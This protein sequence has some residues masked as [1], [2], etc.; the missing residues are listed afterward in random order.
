MSKD[1]SFEL[2]LNRG[3][4]F[5]G[6]TDEPSG[7]LLPAGVGERKAATSSDGHVMVR[8][9]SQIALVRVEIWHRRSPVVGDVV[10][11][12][13]LNLPDGVL[14]VSEFDGINSAR[15]KVG[16][17][18]AHRITVRVDDGGEASRVVVVRDCAESRTPLTSVP[19]HELPSVTVDGDEVLTPTAELALLLSTHDLPLARLAGA[20]KILL[21]GGGPSGYAVR[22]IVEWLRWI[23][24][25]R[26][27]SDCRSLGEQLSADLL[28]TS[29]LPVDDRSLAVPRGLLTALG[30][31]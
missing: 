12:G 8:V 18:G 27:A 1:A 24:P 19:G 31:T 30:A 5:V 11:E 3:L 16:A 28:Q 14:T 10:F 20:I 21:V 25:A 17:G 22:M 7:R 23:H 15:T 9:R 26:R 2:Y 4:L 29:G 13:D 6:S